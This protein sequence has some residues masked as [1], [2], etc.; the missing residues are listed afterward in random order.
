MDKPLW[1]IPFINGTPPTEEHIYESIASDINWN[2]PE[3]LSRPINFTS[4]PP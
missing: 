2:L 1:A 4:Q 3:Y